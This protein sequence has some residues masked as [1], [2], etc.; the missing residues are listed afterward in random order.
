MRLAAAENVYHAGTG[1]IQAAIGMRDMVV[2]H[3]HGATLA[4]PV[5]QSETVRRVSEAVRAGVRGYVLKSQASADLIQAI[6]R[7]LA[8]AVLHGLHTAQRPTE[9]HTARGIFDG[10]FQRSTGTAYHLGAPQSVPYRED[11]LDFA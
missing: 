3:A 2:V 5:E 8:A 9:L 6:R 11:V 1:R 4:C 7:H 10:E